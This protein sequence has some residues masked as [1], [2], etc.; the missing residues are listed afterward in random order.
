MTTVFSDSQDTIFIDYLEKGKDNR[1]V[2][3]IGQ[4][5]RRIDEQ[6]PSFGEEKGAVASRKYT[7]YLNSAKLVD[8]RY[9]FVPHPPF[10]TDM[11]PCDFFLS[12]T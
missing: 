2:G 10:S 12:Q 1:R 8:L 3:I 7:I 9:E 6:T 4:I 11:T 5:S